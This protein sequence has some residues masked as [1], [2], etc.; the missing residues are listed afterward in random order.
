[1]VFT[2]GGRKCTTSNT[3]HFGSG[4]LLSAANCKIQRVMPSRCYGPLVACGKRHG[5]NS[6]LGERHERAHWKDGSQRTSTDLDLG[7][8]RD[9][10][11]GQLELAPDGTGLGLLGSDL[12]GSEDDPLLGYWSLWKMAYNAS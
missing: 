3:L 5:S 10:C 1:M 4:S 8:D 12:S 9:L 11:M 7:S 6:T 2:A